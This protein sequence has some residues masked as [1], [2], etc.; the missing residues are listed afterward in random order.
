MNMFRGLVIRV[1]VALFYCFFMVF[2]V[3]AFAIETPAGAQVQWVGED[4]THNGYPMQILNLKSK[5]GVDS[6][7][8]F[9]RNKWAEPVAQDAPGFIENAIGEWRVIS[10][11][12]GGI[13]TVIQV[14]NLKSGGTEGL[15]SIMELTP[16]S[17]GRDF[18]SLNG[19]ELISKTE[20]KDLGKK[21]ITTIYKNGFSIGANK[22]FY[23]STLKNQGY[24]LV[25]NTLNSGVVV[26]FFTAKG[27]HIE[28]SISQYAENETIVVANKVVD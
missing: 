26:M 6:I 4:I 25:H 18:P 27:A 3:S 17:G 7:L 22:D 10:R 19:T 14:K 5:S 13:N 2:A 24:A 28:V 21:A 12:E 15:I 16:V 23:I 20:S 11:L 9:Y 1:K 8:S